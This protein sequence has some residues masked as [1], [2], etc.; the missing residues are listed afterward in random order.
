MSKTA[1]ELRMEMLQLANDY[2]KAANEQQQAFAKQTFDTA[3]EAG[4]ASIDE[5]AKYAPAFY[6]FG[7]VVK[8]AEELYSFVNKKE[9]E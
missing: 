8:K 5:W 9:R 7:D 6:D 4:K 2:L 1:Y 3:V